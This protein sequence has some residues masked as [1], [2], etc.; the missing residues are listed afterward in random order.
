MRIEAPG[1]R[2]GRKWIRSRARS[3][4]RANEPG[5]MRHNED[6][7]AGSVGSS[8][9]TTD[10]TTSLYNQLWPSL[11]LSVTAVAGINNG[12]VWR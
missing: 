12:E 11:G 2:G 9:P 7:A 8:R 6:A 4:A 10:L 3:Q 5:G 1:R